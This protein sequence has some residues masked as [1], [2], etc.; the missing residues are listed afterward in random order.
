MVYPFAKEGYG[1]A[2]LILSTVRVPM[3]GYRAVDRPPPN[4]NIFH[5]HVFCA[6]IACAFALQNDASTLTL[7][8]RGAMRFA[9][10]DFDNRME[11][12]YKDAAAMAAMAAVAAVAANADFA[13]NDADAA[14][15]VATASA[16][17]IAAEFSR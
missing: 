13:D 4:P 11:G 1:R 3:F 16:A 10:T 8:C 15:V 9:T 6:R 17:A 2:L 5:R 7:Q 12:K 14:V